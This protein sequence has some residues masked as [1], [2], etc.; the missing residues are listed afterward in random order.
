MPF[1][2]GF[3]KSLLG[4]YERQVAKVKGKDILLVMGGTGAGKSTTIQYLCGSIMENQLI[5]TKHGPL[6]H[7]GVAEGGTSKYC[8]KEELAQVAMSAK[9]VSCTQYISV[10]T[11]NNVLEDGEEEVFHICDSPGTGDT[12][13]PELDVANIYGIV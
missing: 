13:G 7:I 3:F 6:K 4:E 10:I 12:R 8:S 2:I 9:A 1:D 11:V 5:I